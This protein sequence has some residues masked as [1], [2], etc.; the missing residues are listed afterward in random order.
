[1]EVG[2]MSELRKQAKAFAAKPE[3]EPQRA[4]I[5]KEIEILL[6]HV[7]T[8]RTQEANR[9]EAEQKRVQEQT[10]KTNESAE[11]RILS[12]LLKQKKNADVV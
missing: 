10:N 7:E 2:R 9:K 12:E 8:N 11:R 3:D 4:L 5:L 1:M 6:E